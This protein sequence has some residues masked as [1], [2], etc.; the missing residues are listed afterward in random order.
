MH[1]D[2][3]YSQ[4][5]TDSSVCSHISCNPTHVLS[6]QVPYSSSR[7]TLSLTQISSTTSI[8]HLSLF[9]SSNPQLLYE[10]VLHNM[11]FPS[12]PSPRP[13]LAMRP[14]RNRTSRIPTS[15]PPSPPR[16]PIHRSSLPS[17]QIRNSA[18]D[19]GH[20]YGDWRM[21]CGYGGDIP[22]RRGDRD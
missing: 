1:P 5:H 20:R 6:P 9:L 12:Y 16:L 19:I 10:R 8:T 17:P 11:A 3:L 18:E 4:R 14:P 2:Y 13:S 21:V 15:P 7:R 22:V